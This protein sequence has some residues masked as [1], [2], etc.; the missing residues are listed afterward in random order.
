MID[1]VRGRFSTALEQINQNYKKIMKAMK[2][3]T[4]EN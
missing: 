4:N 2:L 1:H 3:S